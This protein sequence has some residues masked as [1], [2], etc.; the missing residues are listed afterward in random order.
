MPNEDNIDYAHKIYS[1][2]V[3]TNV[4]DFV[5]QSGRLFYNETTGEIRISDGETPY[6]LP[7]FGGGTSLRLYSEHG[8][9]IT[10][11]VADQPSAIA[12]GDGAHAR[13]IGALVHSSGK[14]THRGDAQTGSY[15]ARAITTDSTFTELFLDGESN[16]LLVEPNSSMAFIIT[17]IARRTDS[18]SNEGAVYE[19]RGGIDRSNTVVS[20]RLIG[21]PSTTIIS[22]DNPSWDIKVSAD[23]INGSLQVMVKGET[24]KTIRWVANIKTVEV[25]V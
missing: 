2:R 25:M 12:L 6:G 10:V 23:G 3:K 20:T 8:T 15:I 13:L 9:P 18:F 22:V 14:F 11:P 7:V 19:I 16:R 4:Y 5:G 17:L 1:G 21:I 24:S